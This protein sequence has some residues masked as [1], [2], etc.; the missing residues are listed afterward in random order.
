MAGPKSV[1]VLLDYSDDRLVRVRLS[2]VSGSWS[3]IPTAGT[4]DFYCVCVCSC[5]F[6]CVRVCLCVCV[7]VRACVIPFVMNRKLIIVEGNIAAG[8]STL[9]RD[10]ASALNYGLFIEPTDA[11]PFLEKYY[12]D[13]KKYALPMQMWFL[14]QRFTTYCQAMRFLLKGVDDQGQKV[15]GVVL[16]RSIFSD[17][18]FAEK[19]FVDENFDAAGY[20]KY[21][22]LRAKLLSLVPM[23]HMMVY[24]DASPETC[25]DRIHNL[26][27]RGCEEVIPLAY[28]AGLDVCYKTLL[29]ELDAS[30]TTDVLRIPWNSFGDSASVCASIVDSFEA[31]TKHIALYDWPEKLENVRAMISTDATI[32]HALD[33]RDRVPVP[34]SSP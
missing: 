7:C 31:S 1:V 11:N 24:L 19:N 3:L 2:F 18:V 34:A 9:C 4:P 5:V 27:K 21:K 14:K 16:D 6:V 23:P 29:D 30:K 28:L 32:Q 12:A 33:A 17:S 20:D 26:R 8:K 13:P 22:R 10:L 15:D 25:Y